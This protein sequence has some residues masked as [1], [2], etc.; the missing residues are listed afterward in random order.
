MQF[1]GGAQ[2]RGV[3]GAPTTVIDRQFDSLH[4]FLTDLASQGDQR[5]LAELVLRGAS[6]TG[7]QD[8]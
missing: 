1:V 5:V 8:Q 7:P 6:P 2:K 4:L 3:V